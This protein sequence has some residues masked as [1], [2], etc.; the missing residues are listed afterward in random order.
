MRHAGR[1]GSLNGFTLVELLV[2]I[3]IIALLIGI[4]LPSLAKARES[5]NALKCSANLR[6]IGQGFAMYVAENRQT[7]PA[8]YL[9][10]KNPTAPETMEPTVPRF[11]YIHWSWFILGEGG[12]DG[13]N[14]G[15]VPQGAFICPSF[16]N[17]GLPPTNP[18]DAD[19]FPG[20]QNDP[21]TQ[22]GIVDRQ[23]PRLSYTV[24][25]AVIP[26]NKFHVGVR[27]TS[28]NGF[29]SQWTKASQIKNAAGTILATEYNQDPRIVS[30][31]AEGGPNVVKS[32]RPVHGFVGRNP[33]GELDISKV[34]PDPLGRTGNAFSSFNRVTTV[35]RNPTP[36]NQDSR[37]EWVGRN[38][39]RGKN[40]RTNF[41]YVDGHVET[42]T[43]EET[44][45]PFEW[46]DTIYTVRNASIFV[47]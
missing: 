36:D 11:G 9:Y 46:G 43:I 17:G 47:P 14:V 29:L 12:S 6:S 41:L 27:G 30:Q 4:L 39:G 5:A 22:S 15:G 44:L 7:F 26:R 23:V 10:V 31:Q 8:A 19:R 2:V 24:N 21:D 42:K 3:G 37:L 13:R 20:Q 32:H 45:K 18:A 28:V 33:L 34:E 35:R 40:A 25:E 38:H 1:R 16:E